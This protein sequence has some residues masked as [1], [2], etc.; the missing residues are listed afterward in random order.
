MKDRLTTLAAV[1]LLIAVV[2]LVVV[3]TLHDPNDGA[4]FGAGMALTAAL[5]AGTALALGLISVYGLVPGPLR[6]IVRGVAWFFVCVGL[7]SVMLL[8]RGILDEL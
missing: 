5:G 7:G 8:A 6:A 3:T 2:G 4:N 1:V